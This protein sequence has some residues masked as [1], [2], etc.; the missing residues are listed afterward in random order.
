MITPVV[1]VIRSSNETEADTS[2]GM[3]MGTCPLGQY[4]SYA[5][6]TSLEDS[7]PRV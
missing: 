2:E 5:P 6:Y 7:P 3:E 4:M 1:R